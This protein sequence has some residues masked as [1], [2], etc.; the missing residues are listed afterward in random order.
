MNKLIKYGMFVLLAAAI[1]VPA[2]AFAKHEDGK[3][4]GRGWKFWQRGTPEERE[5]RKQEKELKKQAKVAEKQAR[6]VEKEGKDHAKKW[7][8]GD[9]PRGWGEGKKTGW[10]G[11]STPPGLRDK[12]H[13]KD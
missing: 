9:T 10:D 12:G 11:E 5:A 1:A 3:S 7:A 13:S 2:P 6:E 4:H 8:D